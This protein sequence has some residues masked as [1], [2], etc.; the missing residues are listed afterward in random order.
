MN[1]IKDVIDAE[2]EGRVRRYGFRKNPTQATTAGV[3]FDINSSPGNPQPKFWFDASPL[4]AKAIYQSVDGGLYHGPNVSPSEK[5][6]RMMMVQTSTSTALPLTLWICDYLLYYPT[7]DDGTTDPQFMNNAVTLPRYQDGKGVQIL[8][9]S[10]AARTG[11]QSFT[12][13][14][15][16]SDG[17]AGRT[18]TAVFQTS[19]ATVGAILGNSVASDI[20]STPF[21]P[22]QSGDSGVR[23]I[24]S[25]TMNGSDV[26][27]FSLILV[28]PLDN[29]LIMG[30]DAPVEKDF[31][32]HGNTMPRIYDDAF[33][34]LIGL[35]Q[36]TLA[37]TGIIGDLKVVWNQ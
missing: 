10:T 15:T 18:T 29:I 31:L 30:I 36:G 24:E 5:F 37:A 32:L 2:L 9:V 19:S 8:A 34:G 23:S 25:V 6:L 17:V 14:Y 16:N 12:I 26:G 28:K 1:G 3:W 13:N 21:I 27:L 7:C 11:G 20:S 22:L 35:P 4:T 33:L